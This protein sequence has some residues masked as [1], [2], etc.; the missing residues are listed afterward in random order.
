M[1]IV[2]GCGGSCANWAT[3]CLVL[4]PNEVDS[5]LVPGVLA[6]SSPKHLSGNAKDAV[7]KRDYEKTMY[8]SQGLRSYCHFPSSEIFLLHFLPFAWYFCIS[9]SDSLVVAQLETCG[10]RCEAA[11]IMNEFYWIWTSNNILFRTVLVQNSLQWKLSK[12]WW[13]YV[14]PILNVESI[15]TDGSSCS[16]YT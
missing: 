6:T 2:L 15:V 12:R 3:H 11:K 14:S 16:T 13:A 5:Q 7:I 4:L 1:S 8:R 10:C 9:I